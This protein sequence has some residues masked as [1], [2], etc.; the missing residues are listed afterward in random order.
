MIRIPS[1]DISFCHS[2]ARFKILS[3][4][5]PQSLC[6]GGVTMAGLCTPLALV[7]AQLQLG[8]IA[9]QVAVPRSSA[10]AMTA[11]CLFHFGSHAHSSRVIWN[12]A[13][14]Y[15]LGVALASYGISV[16]LVVCL[17]W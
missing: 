7:L 4:I 8:A 5:F 16:F 2:L 9:Y 15:S 10:A 11:G 17:W 1:V 12:S 6:C 13:H 14:K 3:Q